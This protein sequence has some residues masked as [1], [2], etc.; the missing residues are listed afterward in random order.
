[1]ESRDTD[2]THYV[3]CECGWEGFSALMKHGYQ[4]YQVGDDCDVEAMDYCP[5]C[6][7]PEIGACSYVTCEGDCSKCRERF[8]CFTTFDKIPVKVREEIWQGN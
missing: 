4:G 1:M 7:A 8:E 5:E 3:K 6:G 2:Y